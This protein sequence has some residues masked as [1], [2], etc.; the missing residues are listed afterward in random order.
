MLDECI[1][2]FLAVHLE[3]KSLAKLGA[4]LRGA[5]ESSRFFRS[6]SQWMTAYW[7]YVPSAIAL[8][9]I[10][11]VLVVL[12]QDVVAQ[13]AEERADGRPPFL[14]LLYDELRRRQIE[15]RAQKKDPNLNLDQ[16]FGRID[17]SLWTLAKQRLESALRQA[18]RPAAEAEPVRHC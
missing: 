6:M 10:T 13:T 12:H 16:V 2:P 11:L 9:H 7:K 3:V 1:D 4:A 18:G 17:K 14:G 5:T 8:K 15:K